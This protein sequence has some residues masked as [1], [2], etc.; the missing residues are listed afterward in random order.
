[1]GESGRILPGMAKPVIVICPGCWAVYERVTEKLPAWQEGSFECTCGYALAHWG[2][3][4]VP[5]FAK[6]KDA[7]R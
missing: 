3:S 6:L 5:K 1:M 7:P 4:I 2:G